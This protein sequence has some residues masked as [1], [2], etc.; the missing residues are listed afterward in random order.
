[1]LKHKLFGAAALVLAASGVLIAVSEPSSAMPGW[2]SKGSANSSITSAQHEQMVLLK[3]A[4]RAALAELDWSADD[5]GHSSET[6]QQARELHMALRAEMASIMR[7]GQPSE[8]RE[9]PS[10]ACPYSGNQDGPILTL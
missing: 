3:E 5:G 9:T 6:M 7:R 10:G 4:Y 1:M 2:S 8:G